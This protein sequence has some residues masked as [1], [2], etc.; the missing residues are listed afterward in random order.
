MIPHTL[1][2]RSIMHIMLCTRP[3]I[4]YALNKTSRYQFNP[5]ECH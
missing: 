2:I 5:G 1:D 4:S 3:N